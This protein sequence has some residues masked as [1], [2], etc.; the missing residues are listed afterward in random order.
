M[1]FRGKTAIVGIGETAHKR[2]WPN[3]SALGL[4]AEAAAEAINDAGLH[5][6]AQPAIRLR[7]PGQI[8]HADHQVVDAGEHA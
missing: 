3:R 5:V 4:A 6:E 7:A 1:S 2:S 8:G